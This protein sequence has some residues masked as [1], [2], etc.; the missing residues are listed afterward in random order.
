MKPTL[1]T[2]LLKLALVG[3]LFYASYTLSNYYAASL[4]YVPEVAFAWERNIP[5]WEWTILPYWSLNLMYAAA[6][7]LCRDTRE[8]NRYVARLVSG[9]NHYHHLLCAV[10]TAF[11]LAEAAYRRVV[12]LAF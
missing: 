2:S 12:G 10:S 1:K 3:I 9:A 4:A 5:F 7:F 6:F 8:Q 11:R